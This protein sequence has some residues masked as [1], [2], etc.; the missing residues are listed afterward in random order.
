MYSAVSLFPYST[1]YFLVF[2][3]SS[4]RRHT[5]SLCDWSSDVCSSDLCFQCWDYLVLKLVRKVRRV[6]EREGPL[7]QRQH[8]LCLKNPLFDEVRSLQ[9]SVQDSMPVCLQFRDYHVD[10]SAPPRAIRALDYDESS[11]DV[12][13]LEIGYSLAVEF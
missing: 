11:S 8:L 4:S 1:Q 5:R 13:V 9:T 12:H 3:F 7:T 2:F 10:L 6:E